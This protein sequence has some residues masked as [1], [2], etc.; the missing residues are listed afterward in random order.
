M[1]DEKGGGGTKLI[2]RLGRLQHTS[3]QEKCNDK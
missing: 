3:T 2:G 1:G